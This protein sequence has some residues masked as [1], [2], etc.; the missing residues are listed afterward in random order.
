[1]LTET[2]RKH[3]EAA[4]QVFGQTTQ[5]ESHLDAMIHKLQNRSPAKV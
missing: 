3:M 4:T 2:I 5:I 1:M